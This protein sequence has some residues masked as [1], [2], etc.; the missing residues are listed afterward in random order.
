MSENNESIKIYRCNICNKNYS[1]QSSLCNHNKKFHTKSNV[2]VCCGSVAVSCGSVAVC[3][4]SVAV[5]CNSD[6]AAKKYVCSFCNRIF[7]HRS[8]K[9]NHEKICKHKNNN[10]DNKSEIVEI[11]NMLKELLQKNCK[12]HPKTLQKINNQLINNNNSNNN[13]GTIINNT[14]V[15]F[16]N[17]QLS[18]LLKHKDML[19]IINKNCL[20]IEELIIRKI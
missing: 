9:F 10:I 6:K 2:A 15:K 1:S 16:G 19:K 17:E 12:I 7:N 4:G 11:K 20:C 3:C 5:S 8:N 13:N 18:S 14:F